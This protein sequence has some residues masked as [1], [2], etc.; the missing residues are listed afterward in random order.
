M[1]DTVLVHKSGEEYVTNGNS[2]MQPGDEV[3]VF[4]NPDNKEFYCTKSGNPL[5]PDTCV[6]VTTGFNRGAAYQGEVVN[7][8]EFKFN[9]N[10][11]GTIYLLQSCTSGVVNAIYADDLISVYTSIGGVSHDYGG[12]WSHPPINV[13]PILKIG[14]NNVTVT[15]ADVYGGTIGCGALYV[16]Q[17]L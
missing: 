7:L 1:G 17:V 12:L 14:A 9:W 2:E 8:G 5:I 15:V 3:I 10:G 11:L 6:R 16:V 4:Q 13:T